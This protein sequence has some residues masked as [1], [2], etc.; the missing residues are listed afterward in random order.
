MSTDLCSSSSFADRASRPDPAFG[1]IVAIA[2][3]AQFMVVLDVAIVDVALPAMRTGLGLSAN[4]Q[5]WVVDGYLVTFGGFLLLAAR[6]GDLLGRKRVFQT[7]LAVFTLAS[8]AGG[9]ATNEAMLLGAASFR[10]PVLPRWP[11]RA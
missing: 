1:V 8:L 11:R 2:C 10:V 9:L 6:A 5:Q 7:G 4:G 3:V